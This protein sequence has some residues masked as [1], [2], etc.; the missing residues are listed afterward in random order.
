[1]EGVV[2]ARRDGDEGVHMKT[3]K[4]VQKGR[5]L[6]GVEESMQ[7]RSSAVEHSYAQ[8]HHT[9]DAATSSSPEEQPP[10][11]GPCKHQ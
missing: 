9:I 11:N 7:R 10:G 5:G 8:A 1:M 4:S 2:C 6:C 3:M